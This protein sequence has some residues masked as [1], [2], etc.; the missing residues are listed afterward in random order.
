MS[1]LNLKM[2]ATEQLILSMHEGASVYMRVSIAAFRPKKTARGLFCMFQLTPQVR[3]KPLGDESIMNARANCSRHHIAK[4]D[5][6][7]GHLR[8]EMVSPVPPSAQDI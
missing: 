2:C 8:L 7:G 5:P 3:A 1:G 4:V 6:H